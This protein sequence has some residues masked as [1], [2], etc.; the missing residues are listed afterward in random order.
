[1]GDGWPAP[2]LQ[3]L[4]RVLPVGAAARMVLRSA[5]FPAEHVPSQADTTPLEFWGRIDEAL[6]AGLLDR[7]HDRVLAAACD[8][9]PANR[10]LC[11]RRVRKVLFVGAGPVGQQ[12]LRSDRELREILAVTR[13]L[14]LHVEPCPAADVTDLR[15][16]L[17]LRPDLL[18][19]ACHGDGENLVFEYPSGRQ[20]G[21][22]A[23]EVASL[24]ETY[25]LQAGVHLQG[26][27]LG[28][29]F[30][31]KIAALFASPEVTVVAHEG[32]L[33]D[34]C[35][36]RFAGQFYEALAEVGEIGAAARIAATHV[37]GQHRCA[38]LP[39]HLVVLE[40]SPQER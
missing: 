34:D 6:S 29:C 38:G 2:V 22:P 31:D 17:S 25:R 9:F 8:R 11:R 10:V 23:V 7:G 18:H 36:V 28:S 32:E 26:I 13:R 24:L 33:D 1:M 4:A 37:A 5:G 27:L 30:S 39:S 3:E 21:I 19:L 12:R 20:H 35:A 14:D 16:L 15:R 40:P